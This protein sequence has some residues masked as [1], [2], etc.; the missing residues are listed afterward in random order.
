MEIVRLHSYHPG[1]LGVLAAEPPSSK[2]VANVLKGCAKV[3]HRVIKICAAMTAMSGF[4]LVVWR[5]K[6]VKRRICDNESAENPDALWTVSR[7]PWQATAAAGL[8]LASWLGT[9]ETTT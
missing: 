3:T 2:G 8:V 9:E 7:L 1:V 4:S 5:L 6:Q